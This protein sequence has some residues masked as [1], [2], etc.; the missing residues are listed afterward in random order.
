MSG[1]DPYVSKKKKKK[2]ETVRK[3]S[4][5]EVLLFCYRSRQ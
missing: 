2:K 4:G 1:I 3:K 5:V